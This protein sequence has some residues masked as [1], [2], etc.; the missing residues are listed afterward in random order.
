[1]VIALLS[2]QIVSILAEFVSSA[3]SN[4]VK[5]VDNA[6]GDQVLNDLHTRG[7]KSPPLLVKDSK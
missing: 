4:I 2:V 5:R 6:K 3:V 7:I 1:M